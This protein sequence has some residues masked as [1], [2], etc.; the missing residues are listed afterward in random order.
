MEFNHSKQKSLAAKQQEIGKLVLELFHEDSNSIT[1]AEV[2]NLD[3]HIISGIQKYS[4][5]KSL[6]ENTILSVEESIK[7]SRDLRT[8][9]MKVLT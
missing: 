4:N 7:R 8:K 2:A 6:L 1:K 5:K 9:L 3:N